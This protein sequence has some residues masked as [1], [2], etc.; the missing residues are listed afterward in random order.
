MHRTAYLS[1]KQ[2]DGTLISSAALRCQILADFS[3]TAFVFI[4]NYLSDK[5]TYHLEI[6][7]RKSLKI[8]NLVPILV[9]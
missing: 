6:R 7:P 9:N 3:F 4:A 2:S 1:T 5:G 8:F